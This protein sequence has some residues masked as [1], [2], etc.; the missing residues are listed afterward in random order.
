MAALE[1]APAEATPMEAVAAALD[2]AADMLGDNRDW[3]C[4]R[5]QLIDAHADLRE[6]ELI[7]MAD[8]AVAFAEA[9]RR[10]GVAEPRR[11]LDGGG[12]HRGVPRCLRALGGGGRGVAGPGHPDARLPR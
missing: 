6:R 11:G 9:L 10:R 4:Q 7:K 1:N 3:S 5:Q 2:E 12:R 8:L